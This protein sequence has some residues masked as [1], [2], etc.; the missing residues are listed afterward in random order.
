M[1][2][3][4]IRFGVAKLFTRKTFDGF[5][6]V[7]QG[8]NF[9]LQAFGGLGFLLDLGVQP[10]DFAP[11]IF[12]L[13]D[14][15]QISHADEQKNS[16]DHQGDDRLGELAPNSEI[17]FHVRSLG[18][19]GEKPKRILLSSGEKWLIL[20]ACMIKVFFL[21]FEPALTWEKIAQARRGFVF[22]FATYLLPF[23]LLVTLAEGWGLQHLGK[24][25]P[26]FQIVRQF[27]QPE[28]IGFELIQFSVLLATIFICSLLVLRVSQTFHERNNYLHAFTLIAYAFSPILLFHLLDV[29]AGMNPWVTWSIGAGVMV[30]ILYQ[31]IPRVLQPDP[32][33]AFGLYLSTIFVVI[34]ISGLARSITAMYLLGYMDFQHS[35][36]TRQ[37]THFLPQ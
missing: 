33:H 4:F 14:E 9:T 2:H 8:V 25:Q 1:H 36:L 7:A 26:K 16:D 10:V 15:R 28:I 27:T 29:S 35:W 19:A 17:N 22:I 24:W 6:I 5:R 23:T 20:C 12:V 30:W 37:L 18:R 32:T 21:I 11:I 34:L 31:G 3:G 13:L